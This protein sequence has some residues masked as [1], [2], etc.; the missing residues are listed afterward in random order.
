[1]KIDIYT[2][3]QYETVR[4]LRR[5]RQRIAKIFLETNNCETVYLYLA[6]KTITPTELW[7]KLLDTSINYWKEVRQNIH[8][9]EIQKDFLKLQAIY[10]IAIFHKFCFGKDLPYNH[11]VAIIW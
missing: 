8:L 3:E 1:M 7:H 2:V 9:T 5:N 4:V 10:E 6:D 11:L